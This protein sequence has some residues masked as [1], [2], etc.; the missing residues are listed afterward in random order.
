MHDSSPPPKVPEPL[1]KKLA[2]LVHETTTPN[3]V[4]MYRLSHCAQIWRDMGFEIE[5]I[6]G[7]HYP[8]DADLLLP[9]V[10]M[11]VISE[12]YRSIFE[13]HP[14]VANRKVV[15]I[16]KSVYSHNLLGRGDTYPGRVIVKT[17]ANYGGF[18]EIR[19][20]SRQI[21]HLSDLGKWK[22][23]L[24]AAQSKLATTPILNSNHYPIFPSLQRVPPAVFDNPH[25]IVEK[26]LPEREGD[27]YFLRSYAFMGSESI[28]VRTRSLSPTVKGSN[29]D[30]LE[31]IPVDEAIARER[32]RLG[33]DYGKFDY[34]M[35]EGRAILLDANATPTFGNSYP[36]E[37]RDRI[38]SVLARGLAQWYPNADLRG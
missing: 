7:P 29:A 1:R 24:A 6:F 3:E 10:D 14:R 34:V 30:N 16:R 15:D 25:L 37:V 31:F 21:K 8:K 17:D 2:I 19:I 5:I 27:S 26:F 28:T 12:D 13:S 23:N 33:F 20:Q 32:E 18:P 11:S 36:P 4:E 35:H 22:N 9:Q 38:A